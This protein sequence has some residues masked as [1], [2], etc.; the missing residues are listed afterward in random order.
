[1][2]SGFLNDNKKELLILLAIYWK[3]LMVVSLIR[4]DALKFEQRAVLS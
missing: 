1:M 3:Q 2:H 4:A